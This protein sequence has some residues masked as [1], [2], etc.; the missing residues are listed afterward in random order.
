M[1]EKE[2]RIAI[3]EAK[4]WQ[5]SLVSN[6]PYQGVPPK[7]HPAYIDDFHVINCPEWS[8]S[9]GAAWEL[10]EE[11]LADGFD[12]IFYPFKNGVYSIMVEGESYAAY[13][14]ADSYPVA[15]CK[16]WLFSKGLEK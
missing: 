5:H 15:I 2:L 16:G 4:G 1:S 7:D 12:V 14:P 3:F 6:F 10:V 9:M 13:K 11:M 8:T